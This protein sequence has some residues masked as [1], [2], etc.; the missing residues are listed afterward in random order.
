MPAELACIVERCGARFPVTDIIYN[1]PR[2][3]GLLDAVYPDP[4]APPL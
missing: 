4:L 2:C 1:C 3:G